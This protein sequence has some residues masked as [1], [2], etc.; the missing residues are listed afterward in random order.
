MMFLGASGRGR[1]KKK[2]GGSTR[3]GK[4]L[5]QD[6]RNLTEHWGMGFPSFLGVL[7]TVRKFLCSGEVKMG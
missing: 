5:G 7:K 3:G 2:K 6:W 4:K 1:L